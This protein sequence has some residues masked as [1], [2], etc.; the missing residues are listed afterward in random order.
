MRIWKQILVRLTMITRHSN[1]AMPLDLWTCAHVNL[2]LS[3]QKNKKASS[4]KESNAIS[5]IIHIY[6][7]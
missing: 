2:L 3:L 7:I 4:G 5:E 1:C 6:D